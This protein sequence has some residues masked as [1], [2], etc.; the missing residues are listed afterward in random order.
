MI[1]K[2][3]CEE[4]YY[5]ILFIIIANLQSIYW[6][7]QTQNIRLE[8]YHIKTVAK[9]NNFLQVVKMQKYGNNQI[10]L[11]FKD[12]DKQNKCKIKIFRQYI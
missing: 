2:C 1:N 12:K 7:S 5:T 6:C 10:E 3:A 11:S 8:I 4:K 9:T